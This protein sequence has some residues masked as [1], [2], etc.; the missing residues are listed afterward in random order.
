VLF[1]DGAAPGA[2]VH[3]EGFAVPEGP[4]GIISI[5]EFFAIPIVARNRTVYVGDTPLVCG[6]RKIVTEKVDA[7]EGG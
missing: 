4:P 7:G 3:L 1:V 5:E 6:D 2:P